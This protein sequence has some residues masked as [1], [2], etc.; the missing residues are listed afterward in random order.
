[1]RG[2][3]LMGPDGHL[4]YPGVGRPCDEHAHEHSDY[5]G[6]GEALDQADAKEHE[7]KHGSDERGRRTVFNLLPEDL[8]SL[9]PVGRL[10]MATTGL[11][12]LTNDTKLSNYLTDPANAIKA[13]DSD[14]AVLSKKRDMVMEDAKAFEGR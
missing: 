9:H 7:R 4:D 11:L 1:M 14:Y 6:D 5:G 13:L 8:Q 2:L 10:D 12:L 3:G